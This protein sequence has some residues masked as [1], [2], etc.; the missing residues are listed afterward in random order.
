MIFVL[1]RV[2][3]IVSSCHPGWEE[4]DMILNEVK[5]RGMATINVTLLLYTLTSA[6]IF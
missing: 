6:L 4:M 3:L 5:M 2:T 1:Y